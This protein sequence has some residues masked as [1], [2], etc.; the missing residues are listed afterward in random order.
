MADSLSSTFTGRV[1]SVNERGLRLEDHE[2][3]YNVSKFAPGVVMP[4]R[5]AV[6][7]IA[8]DSKGFIRSCEPFN[9]VNGSPRSPSSSS[10]RR[11]GGSPLPGCSATSRGDVLWQR[12]S[13][14]GRRPGAGSQMTRERAEKGRW[15]SDGSVIVA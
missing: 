12:T 15:R 14:A 5:G 6:V 4:A 7:T 10:G 9:A 11:S 8:V 3:W 13:G 1:V 2:S